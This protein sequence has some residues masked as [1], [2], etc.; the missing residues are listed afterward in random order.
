MAKKRKPIKDK[1]YTLKEYYEGY[2]WLILHT[3]PY[4][5]TD[6]WL[7]DGGHIISEGYWKTEMPDCVKTAIKK[8]TCEQTLKHTIT[9][10]DKGH[11]GYL[12]KMACSID[13]AFSWFTSKGI[14][15]LYADDREIKCWRDLRRL[16]EGA[17]VVA[18][19]GKK[20]P[21][22][23]ADYVKNAKY[24]E[25]IYHDHGGDV[26]HALETYLEPQHRKNLKE[27]G[28][29]PQPGQGEVKDKETSSPQTTAHWD[30]K[31]LI[32]KIFEVIKLFNRQ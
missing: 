21:L 16:W 11:L 22:G 5:G 3:S 28:T 17:T 9:T 32:D 2:Y 30:W 29:P 8:H 7:G 18:S 27:L 6:G 12:T 1:K 23:E 24:S 15:L 26:F 31:W 13:D 4:H 20:I 25:A 14:P 10:D 19:Y